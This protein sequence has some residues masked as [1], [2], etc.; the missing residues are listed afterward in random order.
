MS[1]ALMIALVLLVFVL[2]LPL[3]MG[4]S[5]MDSCPSCAGV[6]APMAVAMCLAIMSLFVLVVISQTSLVAT[7]RDIPP[8][9]L[10]REPPERPPQIA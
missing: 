8:L 6:D 10:G 4:M 7:R 5:D 1:K 2:G 3:A 9:L